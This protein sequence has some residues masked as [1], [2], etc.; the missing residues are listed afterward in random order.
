MFQDFSIKHFC[1]ISC[2]KTIK[3]EGKINTEKL[4]VFARKQLSIIVGYK[5]ISGLAREFEK[6][7]T[8]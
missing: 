2:I 4:F 7:S 1:S 8:K 3:V 5:N 6:N